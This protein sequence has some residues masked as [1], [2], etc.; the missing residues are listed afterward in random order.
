MAIGIDDLDFDVELEPQT[1]EPKEQTPIGGEESLQQVEETE[2]EDDILT[3][4]LK[5]KGIIDPNKIKI[6]NEEGEIEE[7]PFDSLERDEQLNILKTQEEITPPQ[8]IES[9]LDDS[10]IDLLNQIR[11]NFSNPEEFINTIRQQAVQ[12]FIEQNNQPSYQIDDLSDDELYILDLTAKVPDLS[13]EQ[14]NDALERAKQDMDL[15]SK[16]VGGLRTEYKALEDTQRSQEQLSKQAEDEEQYKQFTDAIV[17]TITSLNKIGNLDVEL[18]NEDQNEIANF[19]LT[20]DEAGMSY[21]AKALNDPKELVNMAWFALHGQETIDQITDYFTEQIQQV[22]KSRY[23]QGLKDA[24]EG[25]KPATKRVAFGGT[26]KSAP[27]QL[28]IDDLED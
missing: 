20:K 13:E 11:T 8:D 25:K 10:E 6:E 2:D 4:L 28:S 18:D 24:Q 1:E 3:S 26:A 22:S 9:E 19:I 7:V 21:F 17:G 16:Q 27:K 5:E 12:E 14:A 23:N 15:Y